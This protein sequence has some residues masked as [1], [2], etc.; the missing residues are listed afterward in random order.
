[1]P[2]NIK[3]NQ[4]IDKNEKPLF[5]AYL[6]LALFIP[7]FQLDHWAIHD[8]DE[9]RNGINAL[10]MLE[11]NDWINL[12]YGGI[13]DHWQAKPPL[14][15]WLL[16]AVF[17]VFGPSLFS[18][19]IISALSA[20]GSLILVYK[21]CRL[22]RNTLFS[23]IPG[24]TLLTVAGLLGVH[25]GRT[26]DFDALLLFFLLAAVLHFLKWVDFK[27]KRSAF[28]MSLFFGLAFLTK[29]F[30]FG[31]LFPGMILYLLFSS[32]F[33]PLLKQSFTWLIAL[34][35]FTTPI[36]WLLIL[37]YFGQDYSDT[38]YAE[39]AAHTIF[40]YDIIERFTNPNFGPKESW[41]TIFY[42]FIY[43]DSKYNYWYF[44]FHGTILWGF[45]RI[46]KQKNRPFL[47]RFSTLFKLHPLALFSVCIWITFALFFAVALN[48]NIWYLTPALPFIAITASYSINAI[49]QRIP[50]LLPLFL[51]LLFITLA[52]RIIING[53]SSN[54]PP[55]FQQV[56]LDIKSS[57]QIYLY[58]SF[59]DQ[60]LFLYT[61]FKNP[62]IRYLTQSKV[63]EEGEMLL[64]TTN[65][66]NK[67]KSNL[68]SFQ[69]LAEE[70]GHLYLKYAPEN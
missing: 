7:I 52:N 9:A 6:I 30:A 3:W 57:K 24:L 69:I 14:F 54:P 49:I 33:L 40:F 66:F 19:R 50:Q 37:S 28:W 21:I 31:I 67:E 15:I 63:W 22:Y 11:T 25:V 70:E 39:N 43:L 60:S 38:R 64:M 17:N 51:I 55:L 16:A 44:F 59:P 61:K 58:K 20:F 1:M 47:Q 29:G 48:K 34:L 68:S 4:W 23:F 56:E 53:K 36:L 2:N 18:L 26:G 35:V 41:D 46:V 10:E 62:N 32:K 8:W 12:Y 13:V 42:F 27:Q 5:I 65:A 45:I